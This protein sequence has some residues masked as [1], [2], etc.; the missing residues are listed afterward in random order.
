LIKPITPGEYTGMVWEGI[1]GAVD[2]EKLLKQQIMEPEHL[3]KALLEQKHEL[4]CRIYT[5][6]CIDNTSVLQ[7]TYYFI[8]SGQSKVLAVALKNILCIR[9][10]KYYCY[11]LMI[12]E[13]RTRKS[14][15]IAQF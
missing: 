8:I 9:Y 13:L 11:Y 7:A 2:T 5:K 4:A 6:S 10:Q 14:H 3:M 12:K 1:V 15:N